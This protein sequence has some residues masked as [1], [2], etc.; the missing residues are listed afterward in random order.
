MKRGTD[1]SSKEEIKV[2]PSLIGDMSRFD[3][4]P[5]QIDLSEFREIK[6]DS[7]TRFN[8]FRTYEEGL[9]VRSKVVDKLKGSTSVDLV[10]LKN[11]DEAEK[12]TD[13]IYPSEE[14]LV[15]LFGDYIRENF[16][17]IRGPEWIQSS[18]NQ[19][20]TD[21]IMSTTN[22]HSDVPG[23]KGLTSVINNRFNS[24]GLL[25]MLETMEHPIEMSRL[26]RAVC[27]LKDWLDTHE[28]M[29]INRMCDWFVT[30]KGRWFRV[31]YGATGFEDPNEVCPTV[32]YGDTTILVRAAYCQIGGAARY[33][34]FSEPIVALDETPIFYVGYPKN[35]S[36]HTL[37]VYPIKDNNQKLI[38]HL[39][40]RNEMGGHESRKCDR[41]AVLKDEVVFPDSLKNFR[42]RKVFNKMYIR[43]SKSYENYIP[44]KE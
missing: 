28:G 29:Y 10:G 16:R 38:C 37:Q 25:S 31:N 12:W 14:F 5:V 30:R 35:G 42:K 9:Y 24:V 22:V 15:G 36:D 3:T 2:E 19:V 34:R 11:F 26:H 32:Q 20:S 33:D 4:K 39:A 17:P 8:D 23:F 21:I 18:L 1:M 43:T 13:H 44:P 27:F 40:Y 6:D 7:G 41:W